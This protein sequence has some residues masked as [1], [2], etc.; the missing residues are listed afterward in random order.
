MIYVHGRTAV[1]SYCLS[2][3]AEKK[4]K[5]DMERA[6]EQ[7]EMMREEKRLRSE[8]DKLRN[9]FAQVRSCVPQP[10]IVMSRHC[11]C[12]RVPLVLPASGMCC[13]FGR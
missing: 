4:Y 8:Q 9:N 6:Q 7:E 13:C 10:V 12:G 1:L 5:K 3:I 11:V 2:Q